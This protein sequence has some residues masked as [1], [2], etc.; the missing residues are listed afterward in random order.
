[1]NEATLDLAI[2][3]DDNLVVELLK[4]HFIDETHITVSL[5]AYNGAD[6]LHQL[7]E[8]NNL[9]DVV[10]LDLSMQKMNGVDTMAILKKEFSSIKIIVLSS[11]YNRSFM[12]FMLKS[13]ANAFMPKELSLDKLLYVLEEVYDKGHYFLPEQIDVIKDQ[14]LTNTPKPPLDKNNLLS[15]REIEVLRLICLQFTAKEIGQKL[16]I[17]QRTVEGHKNRILIKTG[18]KNTA[19]LVIY[20]VQ[21]KLVNPEECF[22]G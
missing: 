14:L 16:F 5:T 18:V 9:P 19:G 12:G 21:N 20:S 10:L 15:E 2:V 13:G 17:T 3:D 4:K 1:M 7:K 11:H 22:L 8:S 6:F